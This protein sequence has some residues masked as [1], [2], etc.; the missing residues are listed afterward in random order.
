M[1]KTE[2]IDEMVRE[3][4]EKLHR[5]LEKL[6][7]ISEQEAAVQSVVQALAHAGEEHV[8]QI[9]DRIGALE[10][11]LGNAC[12]IVAE[13]L[14]KTTGEA[15]ALI[16]SEVQKLSRALSDAGAPRIREL[17]T[18]AARFSED[19]SSL[20]E[21]IRKE[22]EQLE[23]TLSELSRFPVVEALKE[24]RQDSAHQTEMLDQSIAR[25]R[26]ALD[27]LGQAM[28]AL[29]KRLGKLSGE[30]DSCVQ[31]RCAALDD[32]LSKQAASLQMVREELLARVGVLEGQLSQQIGKSVE[33]VLS[34]QA[35]IGNQVR[36][37][38]ADLAEWMQA[39][40]KDVSSGVA[41]QLQRVESQLQG[42]TQSEGL[43][44][45]E[46]VQECVSQL[47]SRLDEMDKTIG[48]ILSGHRRMNRKISVILF[49]AS[50]FVFVVLSTVLA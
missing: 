35:A 45:R 14:A 12:Q 48:A 34:R 50:I 26:A 22:A 24:F 4:M 15:K 27:A 2:E 25:N 19:L 30:V 8:E 49:L 17:S 40:L 1:K 6:T 32:C 29:A 7:Q 28:A 18:V 44:M 43:A 31:S 9:E 41:T 39:Q 46:S 36:Q 47:S 42:S 33:E 38:G 3:Q 23:K 11:G 5:S 37:V 16:E 10:N 21:S 20:G 13:T